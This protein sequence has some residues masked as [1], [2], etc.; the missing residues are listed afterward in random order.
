MQNKSRVMV[1][2]SRGTVLIAMTLMIILFS[3]VSDVF[4]SWRNI[5]NIFRQVSMYGICAVG[6]TLVIMTNGVDLS[7]SSTLGVASV[8]CVVLS[9]MG[10]S[11]GLNA[12]I[13]IIIGLVI[14]I[15]NAF[16]VNEVNMF[17]MMATMG[18]QILLRGLAYIVTNGIP[19]QGVSDSLRFVGQGYVVGIP[20]PV[21]VMLILFTIG[22][23][24]LHKTVYGREIYAVG[25][26][27][28]AARLAGISYKKVR[29]KAYAI[30]GACAAIAGIVYSARVNSGQP[31]AGNAY[32]QNIISACVLG[33]IRMGGG[34]GNMEGVL[35]G[36]MFMGILTNGMV[37]LNVPEFWQMLV[38][39]AVLLAAVSFDRLT[40]EGGQRA[41]ARA[42]ADLVA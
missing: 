3:M 36:V 23:F 16:F 11:L 18:M 41:K 28:E 42:A 10:M 22:I 8:V 40:R 32:E 14:G 34:E 9:S 39:G 37:L 2:W 1:N 24:L 25:G 15:C 17:P 35:I 26:N 27:E 12:I 13:C 31:T 29:Y 30:A 6:M 20:F 7:M 5:R 21:I 33:G 19:V 38:R 4:L